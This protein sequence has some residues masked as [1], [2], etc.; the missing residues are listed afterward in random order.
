MSRLIHKYWQPLEDRDLKS[1]NILS[2]KTALQIQYSLED[3]KFC[4][5]PYFT[6][7]HAV[8]K[9]RLDPRTF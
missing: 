2:F 9:C 1:D 3:L 8:Q 7:K 6:Y 5:A 4:M